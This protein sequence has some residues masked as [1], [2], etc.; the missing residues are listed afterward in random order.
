MRIRLA[1]TDDSVALAQIRWDF[2]AEYSYSPDPADRDSFITQCS[3]WIEDALIS[4]RWHIWVAVTDREEIVSHI[5]IQEVERVPRPGHVEYPWGYVTNVYTRP[6]HRG[7]GI[8]GDLMNA[9][10]QWAR[11]QHYELLLLWPSSNSIG[12]YNR[13]G[14]QRPAEALEKY[15]D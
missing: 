3:R 6:D 1:T 10:E 5:F 14:F 13:H 2:T 12:F 4:A 11:S 7:L 15:L 8:G 9:V